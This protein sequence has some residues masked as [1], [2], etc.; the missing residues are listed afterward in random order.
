MKRIY[1]DALQRAG[2]VMCNGFLLTFKVDS[3]ELVIFPDGRTIVKGTKDINVARG[4]YS[5]YVGT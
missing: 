5:K 2:K 4:L 1:L 3:Y